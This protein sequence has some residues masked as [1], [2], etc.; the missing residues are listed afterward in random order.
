[1]ERTEEGLDRDQVVVGVRYHHPP[2]PHISTR[3][4][5]L[6]PIAVTLKQNTSHDI[7]T[8][9]SSHR[10]SLGLLRIR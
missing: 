6:S 5:Q 2:A 7:S 3:Y 1:M 4:G 9:Y 10:V 8:L